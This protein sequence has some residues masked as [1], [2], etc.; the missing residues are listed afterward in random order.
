MR[1]K[2]NINWTKDRWEERIYPGDLDQFE[3]D[4]FDQSANGLLGC[5]MV[6]LF[7]IPVVFLG[8]LFKLI[9]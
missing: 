5:L 4:Q 6:T 2:K 8:I 7:L 1:L 3:R 9:H